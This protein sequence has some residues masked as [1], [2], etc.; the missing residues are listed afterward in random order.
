MSYTYP[1]HGQCQIISSFSNFQVD[2]KFISLGK[3]EKIKIEQ[4]YLPLL[5]WEEDA[6]AKK[7]CE[8]NFATRIHS[9]WF[10]VFHLICLCN[11]VKKMY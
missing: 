3:F 1:H 8:I 11:G 10:L 6:S 2:S 4:E 9:N 5:R 7:S